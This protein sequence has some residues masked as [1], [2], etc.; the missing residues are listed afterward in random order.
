MGKF[1]DKLGLTELWTACK[2]HFSSRFTIGKGLEL[3][4]DNV[5]NCTLDTSV[6]KIV[7]TLPESPK[8]ED[9][10]KI[11]VVVPTYFEGRD[12]NEV[13]PGEDEDIPLDPL[14]LDAPN[15]Y[16]EYIWIEGSWE[17]IGTIDGN[18]ID[19]S[20]FA[21]KKELNAKQDRLIEG[22]WITI[23]NNKIDCNFNPYNLPLYEHYVFLPERPA[24][25]EENKI[26]LIPGRPAPSENEDGTSTE[27][28]PDTNN[29]RK[30]IWTGN[31]WD[32]LSY[33]RHDWDGKQ[34]ALT[35][36]TGISIDKNN[37]I[38]C[39]LDTTPFIVVDSLPDTPT[40]ANKNKLHLVPTSVSAFDS[41]G[42]DFVNNEFDEYLYVNGKW[43]EIGK[44]QLDI[45]VESFAKKDEVTEIQE[46]LNNCV[47]NTDYVSINTDGILQKEAYKA[48]IGPFS[49]YNGPL[50]K[51]EFVTDSD[52]IL[53]L[54]STRLTAG[55]SEAYSSVE[56]P[57]AT[58]T[59]DGTVKLGS[60][61]VQ[62]VAAS[63]V[64]STASRT[65][66]IQMNNKYQL[67]VN[68]PWVDSNRTTAISTPAVLGIGQF[69]F[70]YS[71]ECLAN[72]G[73]D[74][75]T[76][77]PGNTSLSD[78]MESVAKGF[79][80]IKCHYLAKDSN[81]QFVADKL[82]T[83]RTLWGRSFDGSGNVTGAIANTG[84]ITPSADKTYALGSSSLRYTQGLFSNNIIIWSD[85][86][87]SG[88]SNRTEP[89]TTL[90]R[91]GLTFK[92]NGS[93]NLN[94]QKADGTRDFAMTRSTTD[95]VLYVSCGSDLDNWFAADRILVGAGID[96]KST[97]YKLIVGGNIKCTSLTGS[98]SSDIRLKENIDYSV[99]YLK[100]LNDLGNVV[101]YN[102]TKK[103]VEEHE[104]LD[105]KTHTGL[106][107]QNVE[108]S[109]IPNLSAKDDDG[110]GFINYYSPDLIAT[111]IGAIQQLTKR[112]EELEAKLG[113]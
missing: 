26:I 40:S 91:D 59:S 60:D 52:G 89:M 112:V 102:Y 48:L 104:G 5:L 10:N 53:R 74:D 94:F 22:A 11:H 83:S 46:T 62:T 92:S 32:I 45:D 75:I 108:G 13:D 81:N 72:T 58:S 106:I 56:V 14:S 67:V 23:D 93:I 19:T 16:N 99:D 21:T 33:S 15:Q 68:V 36:G 90:S 24:E 9:I 113:E 69:T 96:A 54:K 95:K 1:L 17:L 87:S 71:G 73:F 34:D 47:K 65:Y 49:A 105:D 78:W 27:F 4:K 84:A 6:F 55:G 42:E 43:E 39:T 41:N 12:D 64:S 101:E 2:E 70:D 63:A 28:R 82:S 98:V 3:T 107:Y 61:A 97:D 111:M 77:V 100:R 29:Y 25:G 110:H 31:E 8:S 76:K 109:E 35:P 103:A 30:Y 80:K 50:C 57:L 37:V 18:D 86:L 20:D 88:A 7:R 38:S 85:S 66:A 44:V 79:N 51:L